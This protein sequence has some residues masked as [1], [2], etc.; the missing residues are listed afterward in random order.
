MYCEKC[1]TELKE[2]ARF[3]EKCGARVS[4]EN[5]E[6]QNAIARWI[7]RFKRGEYENIKIICFVTFVLLVIAS[8]MKLVGDDDGAFRTCGMWMLYIPFVITGWISMI[9]A[10]INIGEDEFWKKMRAALLLRCIPIFLMWFIYRFFVQTEDDTIGEFHGLPMIVAIYGL[11]IVFLVSKMCKLKK[12]E[13]GLSD[14]YK[15][16]PFKLITIINVICAIILMASAVLPFAKT[17]TENILLVQISQID[18]LSRITE[19]AL[20]SFWGVIVFVLEVF[21]L[22]MSFD[23]S[24]SNGIVTFILCMVI[25][26]INLVVINNDYMQIF[27]EEEDLKMASGSYLMVVGPIIYGITSLIRGILYRRYEINSFIE[28]YKSTKR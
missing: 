18:E 25:L 8:Y 15:S 9:K 13:N 11:G 20:M 16:K 4:F 17:L 6:T 23:E 7:S 10:V 21:L 14:I 5:E 27:V 3:C 2:N 22:K 1:G 28:K 26:I 24:F 12:S 19:F